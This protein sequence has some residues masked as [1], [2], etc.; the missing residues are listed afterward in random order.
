MRVE[1]AAERLGFGWS[2]MYHLIV[3]GAVESVPVGRLRRVP[4]EALDEYVQRLRDDARLRVT[5]G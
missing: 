1:E 5:R 4:V 3:T 2:L